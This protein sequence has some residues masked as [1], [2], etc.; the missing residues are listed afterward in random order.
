MQGQVVGVAQNTA[1]PLLWPAR[2]GRDVVGIFELSPTPAC[3]RFL[4]DQLDHIGPEHAA[5]GAAFVVA[6][7]GPGIGQGVHDVL[8]IQ[9]PQAPRQG[10]IGQ[11]VNRQRPKYQPD[12]QVRTG[13]ISATRAIR[14]VNREGRDQ[15]HVQQTR[16][17]G[18]GGIG[19]SQ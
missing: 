8:A 12:G 1:K 2:E 11:P 18:G 19:H 10:P 14:P 3:P 4:A 7:A 15:H 13:F 9:H 5:A 17:G 16:A 6:H